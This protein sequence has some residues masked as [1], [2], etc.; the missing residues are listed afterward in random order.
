MEGK[1]GTDNQVKTTNVAVCLKAIQDYVDMDEATVE[2]KKGQLKDRAQKA[3]THLSILL[4]PEVKNV[5]VEPCPS[6]GLPTID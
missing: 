1:M 5:Y 4:T 6:G 3:M 2:E